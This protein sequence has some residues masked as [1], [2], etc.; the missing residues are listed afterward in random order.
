MN[1]V[2]MPLCTAAAS[3]ASSTSGGRLRR[4]TNGALVLA[5]APDAVNVSSGS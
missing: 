1:S 4:S 3:R 2:R 5:A